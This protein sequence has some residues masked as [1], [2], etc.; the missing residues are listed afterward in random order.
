[1]SAAEEAWRAADRLISHLDDATIATAQK[2][3][4][5]MDSIGQSR[6][7]ALHGLQVFWLGFLAR[8]NSY[9]MGVP[10]VP[11]GDL[12]GS[13]AWKRI[14]NVRLNLR[15]PVEQ[16]VV[17]NGAIKG[18]RVQGELHTADYY[19]SSLPFERVPSLVPELKLDL[20]QVN[21]I[22]STGLG[23]LVSVL[24]WWWSPEELMFVS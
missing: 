9:Q 18:A 4:S 12:Y 17:E 10:T 3:F 7:A 21:F 1:M 6:M 5:R 2:V 11:L 22:D 23:M 20:G 14:S 16:L 15:S 24:K 19:V 13:D 8:A